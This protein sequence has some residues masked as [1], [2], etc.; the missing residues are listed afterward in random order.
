MYAL[1]C[2][3]FAVSVNVVASADNDT[4]PEKVIGSAA[5]GASAV[6]HLANTDP[7]AAR[8]TAAAGCA[9]LTREPATGA[10]VPCDTVAERCEG[11]DACQPP[12]AHSR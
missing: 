10:G 2:V 11:H 5:D 1:T 9:A 4:E 8:R 3:W 6:I 7:F 12:A